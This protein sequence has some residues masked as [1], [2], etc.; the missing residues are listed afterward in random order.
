MKETYIK[1]TISSRKIE[2][3]AYIM[4]VSADTGDSRISEGLSPTVDT[5]TET[6]ADAWGD[7]KAQH[8]WGD[9]PF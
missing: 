8:S 5:E 9:D 4:A 7:V 2:M 3:H 6:E 1:P